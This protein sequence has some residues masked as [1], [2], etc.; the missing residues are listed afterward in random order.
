MGILFSKKQKK[1]CMF[2]L[3]GLVN[4]ASGQQVTNQHFLDPYTM[5]VMGSASQISNISFDWSIGE[6]PIA[7]MLNW[8][9]QFQ[10][11]TGFLQSSYYPQLLFKHLDSFEVEIK[12]GPN[13]FSDRIIIQSK[14]DEI[15][16]TGIQLIDFQ[17]KVLFTS[18][19]LF[20]GIQFYKEIN[21]RKLLFPICFLQIQ[22]IIS[23]R[24]Y[25]TKY[26]KLIQH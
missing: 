16:I 23:D 12:V 24:I 7:Q 5:N 20:S 1:V 4:D 26:L 25:N 11:S 15:M 18:T 21:I 2:F 10:L 9:A 22:Y 6:A 3:M 13:P 17:G 14:V 19:E 8:Q